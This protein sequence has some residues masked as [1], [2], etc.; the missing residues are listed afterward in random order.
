MPIR[1]FAIDCAVTE[2]RLANSAYLGGVQI[3]DAKRRRGK[4]GRNAGRTLVALRR[5]V[6][7]GVVRRLLGV[8]NQNHD[9]RRSGIRVGVGTGVLAADA[10]DLQIQVQARLVGTKQVRG[11]VVDRRRGRCMRRSRCAVNQVQ[12]DVVVHQ[13]ILGRGVVMMNCAVHIVHVVVFVLC[14]VRIVVRRAMIEIMI[15]AVHIVLAMRIAV[16]VVFVLRVVRQV[17]MRVCLVR[18]VFVVH[19]VVQMMRSVVHVMRSVVLM[20][21]GIL[22]VVRLVQQVLVVLVQHLGKLLVGQR[23]RSVAVVA[24]VHVTMFIDMVVSVIVEMA[25]MIIDWVPV[26][27]KVMRRVVMVHAV[28]ATVHVPM[29]I[30]MRPMVIEMARV[31]INRVPMLVKVMRRV[32]MVHAVVADVQ[33]PV[34]IE[35]AHVIVD[36]MPML[37]KVMRHV[38]VTHTVVATIHV[39]MFVNMVSSVVIDVARVLVDRM[40]MR[41]HVMRVDSMRWLDTRVRGDSTDRVVVVR[42]RVN[43][44]VK[45]VTVVLVRRRHEV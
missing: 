33:V 18:H 8:P 3:L 39:P 35:M 2:T 9:A 22:C 40:P 20:M 43:R 10:V 31:I 12:T 26:L 36:R 4:E 27:V 42:R 41:V 28:V 17:V 32:V 5:Q 15:G 1:I 11:R 37:V 23:V 29:L 24:A 19:L 34:L 21:R 44:I 7:V 45:Q 16:Q 38:A 25:R 13:V 6:R 14:V 30:D